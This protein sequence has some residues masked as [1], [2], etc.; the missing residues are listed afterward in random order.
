MEQASSARGKRRRSRAKKER[1]K[2]VAKALAAA[3]AIAGGTQAY[4]AP[5]RFDNPPGPEHFVWGPSGNEFL[6]ITS[7]ASAQ[8]GSAVAPGVFRQWERSGY[9]SLVNSAAPDGMDA[10][11]D[12]FFYLLNPIAQGATI[13]TGAPMA[14]GTF[15][16]VTYPGYEGTLLP[17]GVETYLGARFD[18]GAGLQYGWVGVVRSGLELE[19]FAWGYESDAG[20][21]I[22][23]GASAEDPNCED[24]H[25]PTVSEYGLM[26][27]GLGVLAAGAWVARKRR[28]Q[29]ESE[30]A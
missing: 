29:V 22:C 11:L 3:A 26:G 30:P 4:A 18:V 17:E 19:A 21:P 16:V 10:T 24:D 23:A 6:E 15:I 13:P 7:D 12:V 27:M 2:R 25:I 9:G 28:P 1:R 8:S 14:D 20:V 5:V